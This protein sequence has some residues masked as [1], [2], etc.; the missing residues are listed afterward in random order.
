MRYLWLLALLGCGKVSGSQIDAAPDVPACAGDEIDGCGSACAV[1][2]TTEDREVPVCTSGSCDVACKDGVCSDQS[3]SKLIWQFGSGT[4]DGITARAPSGLALA[5]RNHLGSQALA[6]DVT[7]LTEISFR[8]PICVTGTATLA[9]KT[10]S[11][12]IFF[13]GGDPTG[14]QY[15]TQI[16]VPNAPPNGDVIVSQL[17][18]QA[19]MTKHATGTVPNTAN[20][21]AAT[22]ITVQAGTFGA[23]FSG[24]IWFDNIT[25]Q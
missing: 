19:G 12:D 14:E 18:V 10:L 11:M 20:A 2:D 23:A 1:C 5:V 21:Q 3:C 24:T 4:V 7:S 15:Y 25:L 17:G 8:M 16:A 22:E 13:E 6:A 9:N